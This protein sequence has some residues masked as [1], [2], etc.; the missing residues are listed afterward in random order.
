MAA[1]IPIMATAPIYG[2]AISQ[3]TI[4]PTQF[5][6]GGSLSGSFD[7]DA[8]TGLT[9]SVSILTTDDGAIPGIVWSDASLTN[10]NPYNYCCIESFADPGTGTTLILVFGG[11]RGDLYYADPTSFQAAINLHGF[12][13]V[14]PTDTAVPGAPSSVPEPPALALFGVGSLLVGLPWMIGRRQKQH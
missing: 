13:D 3:W 6:A 7:F 5:G 9:S 10:T 8:S 4:T 14:T 2:D 12:N 1:A 11:G